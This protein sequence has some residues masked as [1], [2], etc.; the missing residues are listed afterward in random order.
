MEFEYN[1]SKSNSNKQKHGISFK[2]AKYLWLVD[3]IVLPAMTKGEPRYMLIGNIRRA[4]YSCIF[5]I[6][7]GKTRIISCRRSREKER[8]LYHEAIEK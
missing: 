1:I 8:R 6:R 5:T 3:N 7:S 2:E 4:C